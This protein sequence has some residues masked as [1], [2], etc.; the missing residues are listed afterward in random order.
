MPEN[1]NQTYFAPAERA[2]ADTVKRQVELLR[3]QLLPATMFDAVMEIVLILNKERQTVFFNKN[4]LALFKDIDPASVYGLRPG[5]IFNCVNARECG[6]GCGTSEFCKACGAVG[7]ILNS[8]QGKPD[9]QEC[10]LTS[11][12]FGSLDLMIMATPLYLNDMDFTIYTIKDI[13]HEKRRAVLE[14]IFFHD[15]ANTIAGLRLGADLLKSGVPDKQDKVKARLSAGVDELISLINSQRIL[16]QAENYELIVTPASFSA[17]V[18]LK[19]LEAQYA[20]S[21]GDKQ[22]RIEL[23]LPEPDIAITTDRALLARVLSNMIKNAVE[24]IGADEAVAVGYK[25]NGQTI[26]FFVKNPGQMPEP[27]R[28]QIFQRSF[29]TKGA[30]RGVGAYSMKLISERYLKGAVSF[31][32]SKD[33]GTIFT[34]SYPLSLN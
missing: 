17:K 32:S 4:L 30:G 9:T 18:L 25:V 1:N 16:A 12:S 3:G 26:D 10:R 11:V 21:A 15:A 29:S 34:A 31:S 13:S 5:E 8:Q 19:D 20:E 14:R 2:P 6:G 23:S 28:L 33:T 24:A 27:A 7:A 22:V